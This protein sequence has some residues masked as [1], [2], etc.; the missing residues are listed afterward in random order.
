MSGKNWRLVAVEPVEFEKLPVEV[1]DWRKFTDHF[2]GIYRI[3]IQLMKKNRKLSTCN[4]L[5][6]KTLARIL[7]SYAQIPPE[8]WVEDFQRNV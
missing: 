1:Q 2:R 6:L 5:D 4:R 8:H 3:Y 7:T